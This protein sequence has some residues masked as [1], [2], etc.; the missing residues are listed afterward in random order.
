M[1]RL[2]WVHVRLIGVFGSLYI[3]V[4][5]L[6]NTLLFPIS[7]KLTA[8]GMADIHSDWIVTE[9]NDTHFNYLENLRNLRHRLT[10]VS[11]GCLLLY[12]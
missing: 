5:W 9:F 12:L 3:C 6:N 4:E 8:N 11:V 7:L 2:S 1:N 10:M